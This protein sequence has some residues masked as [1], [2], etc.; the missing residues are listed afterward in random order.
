MAT[1][2]ITV[3]IPNKSTNIQLLKYWYK[4]LSVLIFPRSNLKLKDSQGSFRGKSL[5]IATVGLFYWSK[6]AAKNLRNEKI[7]K[8]ELEH[9]ICLFSK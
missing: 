3:D 5:E 1:V 6:E 8:I 2:N 7:E 9:R 4:I